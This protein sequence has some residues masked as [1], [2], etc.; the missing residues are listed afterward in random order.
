MQFILSAQGLNPWVKFL[1]ILLNPGNG[2]VEMDRLSIFGSLR[3]L[4]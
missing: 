2:L 3:E 4:H 1:K